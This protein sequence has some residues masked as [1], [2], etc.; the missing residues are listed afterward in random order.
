M[1]IDGSTI[2]VTGAS[3][4][5]GAA[6]APALRVAPEPREGAPPEGG[7]ASGALPDFHRH[8]M[9]GRAP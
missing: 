5:I 8:E 9:S 4:G 6:L 3:S 1:R 2:F 7:P